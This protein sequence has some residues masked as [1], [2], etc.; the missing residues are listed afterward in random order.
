MESP[1]SRLCAWVERRADGYDVARELRPAGRSGRS[2][3]EDVD[4]RCAQIASSLGSRRDT[5][6]CATPG[7]ASRALKVAEVEELVLDPAPRWSRQTGS[8][9]SAESDGRSSSGLGAIV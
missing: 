1:S 5:E 7:V 6:Q 4:T 2:R 9:A 8:I 3:V